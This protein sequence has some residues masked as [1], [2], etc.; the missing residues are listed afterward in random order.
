MNM[1]YLLGHSGVGSTLALT[2]AA[3]STLASGLGILACASARV[4]GHRLAN[5]E[6]VADQAANALSCKSNTQTQSRL[7]QRGHT[8]LN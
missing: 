8:P 3:V 2:V 4:H 7:V 6:T 1:A 5:D